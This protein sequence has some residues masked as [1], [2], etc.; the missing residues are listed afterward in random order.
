MFFAESTHFACSLESGDVGYCG[1]VNGERESGLLG[2]RAEV[3]I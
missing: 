2:L 3:R 1:K